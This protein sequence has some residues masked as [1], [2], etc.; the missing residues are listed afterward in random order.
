MHDFYRKIGNSE[1]RKIVNENF[2]LTPDEYRFDRFITNGI[3]SSCLVAMEMKFDRDR[4]SC[5][6]NP[7][8]VTLPS[9]HPALIFRLSAI[10]DPSRSHHPRVIP[11]SKTRP[12]PVFVINRRSRGNKVTGMK[13]DLSFIKRERMKVAVSHGSINLESI[14]RVKVG[15]ARVYVE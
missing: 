7:I 12:C 10:A 9:P 11:A 8:T 2:P 3:I 14:G 15:D 6:F 4:C 13:A 1:I 5:P